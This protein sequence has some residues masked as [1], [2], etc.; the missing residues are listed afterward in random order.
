[1]NEK[2][3]YNLPTHIPPNPSCICHHEE[4]VVACSF[5]VP[6]SIQAD[7]FMIHAEL[8]LVGMLVHWDFLLFKFDIRLPALLGF[9]MWELAEMLVKHSAVTWYIPWC[10]M[11]WRGV[12]IGFYWDPQLCMDWFFFLIF[13]IGSHV[14]KGNSSFI[15]LMQN[16]VILLQVLYEK[17][18]PIQ[19]QFF[20]C[21][22]GW[23]TD[24]ILM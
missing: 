23:P 21:L 3:R 10:W 2:R 6:W 1:M 7:R 24:R 11:E 12:I 18:F 9:L 14:C 4:G 13:L 20:V 19:T 16:K 8:L 17:R 15:Y 5:S 22:V